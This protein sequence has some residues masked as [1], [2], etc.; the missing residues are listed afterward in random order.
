MME[1]TYKLTLPENL[2]PVAKTAWRLMDRSH[3]LYEHDGRLV[4]V[5]EADDLDDPTWEGNS[6][7][8]LERW[9]IHCFQEWV[10]TGPVANPMWQSICE[11]L[12]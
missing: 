8:E 10:A 12:K 5:E 2:D 1:K 4:V 9:L 6:Y 3:E 7:A 11:S